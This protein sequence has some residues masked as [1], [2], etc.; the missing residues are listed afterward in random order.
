MVSVALTDQERP[1][2]YSG[3]PRGLKKKIANLGKNPCLG[4]I[5]CSSGITDTYAIFFFPG[6]KHFLDVTR[7]ESGCFCVHFPS[8]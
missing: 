7:K 4:Q 3:E 5:L 1:P 8:P 2:S 6:Y